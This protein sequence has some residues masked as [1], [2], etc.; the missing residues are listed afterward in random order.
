MMLLHWPIEVL[1]I[2]VASH[3]P[4]IGIHP[5]SAAMPIRIIA[6]RGADVPCLDERDVTAWRVGA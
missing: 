6:F 5:F 3:T 2:P 4:C 1:Y